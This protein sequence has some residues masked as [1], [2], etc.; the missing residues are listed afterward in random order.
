MAFSKIIAESMDL[1]DTYAFTGTVTGAGESNK[2]YFESLSVMHIIAKN[3]LVHNTKVK[4]TEVLDSAS[5]MT[6]T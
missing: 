1:T 5:I 2:P 3:I 6:N 4:L